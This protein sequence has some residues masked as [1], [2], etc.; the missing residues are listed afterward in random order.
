MTL[1]DYLKVTRTL[2]SSLPLWV[3]R[4]GWLGDKLVWEFPAYQ[5]RWDEVSVVHL[6]AYRSREQAAESHSDNSGTNSIIISQ[7]KT[8]NRR[9]LRHGSW[10]LRLDFPG[11]ILG[12]PDS[13]CSQ[14]TGAGERPGPP[15]GCRYPPL[16]DVKVRKGLSRFASP[17]SVHT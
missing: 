10:I 16:Y 15:G 12:P 7:Y 11:C 17:F 6:I 2:L 13:L 1:A 14:I 3:R 5:R 4:F 9:Q 8:A